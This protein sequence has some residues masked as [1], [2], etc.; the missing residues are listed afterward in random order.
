MSWNYRIVRRRKKLSK[1][2]A[3]KLKDNYPEGYVESFEIHEAY[4]NKRGKLDGI[5]KEPVTVYAEKYSK[6]EF[7][8]TLKWMRKAV[9]KPVIDYDTC[10]EI[11]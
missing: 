2:M 3:K 11:K 8:R 10:K 4:Y 9:T 1:S 6:A 7:N 5:T